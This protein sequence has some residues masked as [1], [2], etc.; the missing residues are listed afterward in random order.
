MRSAA[1]HD[2]SRTNSAVMRRA[3]SAS[4]SSAVTPYLILQTRNPTQTAEYT[5][6]ASENITNTA[7]VTAAGKVKDA[8]ALHIA[9][10]QS[11]PQT[12]GQTVH[13]AR[14]KRV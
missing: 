14:Q 6:T 1:A 10:P 4:L 13:T 9:E 3:N 5:D 8:V 11:P 7:A 2:T 12:Q